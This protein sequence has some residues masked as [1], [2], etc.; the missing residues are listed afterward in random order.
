MNIRVNRLTT[1]Q[2]DLMYEKRDQQMLNF[3]NLATILN[4]TETHVLSAQLGKEIPN[5]VYLGVINWLEGKRI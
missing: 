3:A 5:E 1:I 4:C 2:R